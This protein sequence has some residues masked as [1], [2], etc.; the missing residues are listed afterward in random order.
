MTRAAP[1]PCY[2]RSQA[3]EWNY[4]H[5]PIRWMSNVPPVPGAWRFCGLSVDS[6]LGIAAGPLLNGRWIL[7]YASLGFDVLTYKT[8]RSR[9]R[10]ATTC[11]TCSR[12]TASELTGKEESVAATEQM[13][14]TWAVSFGM[15]SRPPDV[16]R[17]DVEATRKKLPPRQAAVGVRGRHDPGRLEHR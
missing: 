3:Y 11:R 7:Y 2:D 12:S 17:A 16:W 15:P 9:A 14:G 4:E 10:A 8:V 1:L 6:P 13:R 5:A